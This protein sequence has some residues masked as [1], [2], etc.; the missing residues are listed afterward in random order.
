MRI[1]TDLPPSAVE[2][3][4]TPRTDVPVSIREIKRALTA[5]AT[6]Y[7]FALVNDLI[8]SI[9]E[10]APTVLDSLDKHQAIER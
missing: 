2:K 1:G 8:V 10:D 4:V 6:L 5:N 9:G 3:S 7:D